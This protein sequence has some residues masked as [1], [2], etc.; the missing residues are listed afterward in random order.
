M[1]PLDLRDLWGFGEM[2]LLPLIREGYLRNSP[3]SELMPLLVS[4]L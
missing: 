3:A 4:S 2:Q 1:R